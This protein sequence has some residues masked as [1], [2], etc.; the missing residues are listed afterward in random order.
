MDKFTTMKKIYSQE[1]RNSALIL[2]LESKNPILIELALELN[3]DIAIG[4]G[5]LLN[6]AI[7]NCNMQLVKKLM[8]VPE[9]VNNEKTM[10]AAIKLAVSSEKTIWFTVLE[11][12]LKNG[13]SKEVALQAVLEYKMHPLDVSIWLL[14]NGAKAFLAP[15]H[16][17][18]HPNIAEEFFK[19]GYGK[20]VQFSTSALE[21]FCKNI[22]MNNKVRVVRRL[23][24][25]RHD[26]VEKLTEVAVIG[27][28][29]RILKVLHEENAITVINE[30]LFD[31]AIRNK[32][33]LTI[34]YIV[35]NNLYQVSRL[36]VISAAVFGNVKILIF[37]VE[38]DYEQIKAQGKN[39]DY[40]S[41]SI[42]IEFACER[43]RIDIVVALLELGYKCDF[44]KA[45]KNAANEG[46][47]K[48]VDILLKHST[49]INSATFEETVESAKACGKMRTAN[50]MQTYRSKNPHKFK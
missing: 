34:K 14:E 16:I 1:T 40:M 47:L 48:V 3:P 50:C 20:S 27:G 46:Y 24:Q 38:K 33:Y 21:E 41:Y 42:A 17:E 30:Y 36:N 32:H 11:E 19:Q 26:L 31:K 43:N 49:I 5:M 13:G 44:D 7:T 25:D 39:V 8:T 9:I 45:I 37:L 4:G 28:Y 10:N 35:E 18:K 29:T 6:Y 12:L 2:A 22:C 23:I 15:M